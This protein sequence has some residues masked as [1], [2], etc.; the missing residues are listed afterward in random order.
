MLPRRAHRAAALLLIAPLAVAACGQTAR[1]RAN[2]DTATA[3]PL[4]DD[5][6]GTVYPTPTA[7]ATDEPTAG[8]TGPAAFT[9]TSVGTAENKYDPADLTVKLVGG[10]ATLTVKAEGAPHTWQSDELKAFNS[11]TVDAGKTKKLTFAAKEGTFDY[12]CLFHKSLG[13]VGKITLK[14]DAGGSGGAATSIG[15]AENKYDPPDLTL[16]AAAGKVTLNVEAQGAP[17]TW[18]S[19]ELKAF[20]SGTVN[21][22]EK[23]KLT[24]AAKPGTYEYYCLFHKSLGMV[25]KLTVT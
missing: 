6:H 5:I 12:Y 4:S 22:G 8:P 15:T 23:K 11:G 21:A 24:F 25:G 10:K 17:H 1:Q 13:M 3:V 18:Q 14:P 7:A 9:D 20:N 2:K 16:K 19:D